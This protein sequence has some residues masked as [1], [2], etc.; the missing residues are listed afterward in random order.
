[1]ASD[2]PAPLP[3]LSALVPAAHVLVAF[4]TLVTLLI[5]YG[6]G[7]VVYRLYFSPLARFPGPK[8]AACSHWYE[9]Y[10]D[11]ISHGGGIFPFHIKEL[12][13]R[14]GPIVRINPWELHIDDPEYYETIYGQSPPLDKLKHLEKRFGMPHASFSTADSSLHRTRRAALNPFLST[15]R[16]QSHEPLI[17]AKLTE[18]CE[19][20]TNEYVGMPKELTLNDFFA[21]LTAD[22]VMEIAFGHSY[23]LIATKDFLHPYTLSTTNTVRAVHAVTHMPWIVTLTDMLPEN[24]L[25]A[26]SEQL[27]PII[28]FRR[29][30][31]GA[32]P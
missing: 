14:Y 22:V 25:M 26:V 12:H 2:F 16:I 3:F 9:A 6:T 24:L 32:K 20:L 11:L 31:N 13:D 23:N 29:V 15:R 5:V 8:L 10:F 7:L 19:R 30:R 4:T 1:M 21:C 17:Q 27:R 28:Q 18:I